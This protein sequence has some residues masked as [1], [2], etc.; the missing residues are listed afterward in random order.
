MWS[1]ILL[2]ILMIIFTLKDN[3]E[4]FQVIGEIIWAFFI[5]IYP[6]FRMVFAA[7]GELPCPWTGI[8]SGTSLPYFQHQTEPRCLMASCGWL[9][10]VLP[11]VWLR[12][13]LGRQ[14]WYDRYW[15]KFYRLLVTSGASE[16][17]SANLDYQTTGIVTQL[18]GK[19]PEVEI[20]WDGLFDIVGRSLSALG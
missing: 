5:H 15:W 20:H 11:W 12:W 13:V 8:C 14:G 3:H 6:K 18:L 16:K 17:T 1:R 10:W 9:V 4:S 2:E 19:F 7:S